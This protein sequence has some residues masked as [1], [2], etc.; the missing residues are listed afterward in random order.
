MSHL[1]KG[2]STLL[3]TLLLL[4]S[5]TA[6]VSAE[7][8]S[9]TLTATF[10]VTFQTQATVD[11]EAALQAALI[12]EH[13]TDIYL[14]GDIVLSQQLIN[15]TVNKTYTIYGQK[16]TVSAVPGANFAN[17][18]AIALGIGNITIQNA[19]FANIT[20]Q[21]IIYAYKNP[22]AALAPPN[23]SVQ[24]S[25]CTFTNGA[26]AVLSYAYTQATNV[27][28]TLQGN[29]FTGFNG[30]NGQVDSA[31]IYIEG[32]KAILGG[33]NEAEKNTLSN[34]NY[35][36]AV[37]QGVKIYTDTVIDTLATAATAGKAIYTR[38]NI[39]N[40]IAP[41]QGADV[42]I[43]KTEASQSW[44][45]RH[46]DDIWLED[47]A[48][49]PVTISWDLPDDDKVT[50]GS[51]INAVINQSTAFTISVSVNDYAVDVE[52]ATLVL[53]WTDTEANPIADG[54]TVT[55]TT[56]LGAMTAGSTTNQNFTVTFNTPG[57]YNISLYAE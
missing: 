21:H 51:Q 10:T 43:L 50:P 5:V 47:E 37:K 26:G 1:Q 49:I 40:S 45:A 48:L 35:G 11:N 57:T 33:T 39:T 6:F 16:H 28:S 22:G 38:N 54:I 7:P 27:V 55:G 25:G 52:N 41:P 13:I 2:V 44:Y 20:A 30:N 53:Q 3:I 15:E 32:G 9:N 4:F 34:N 18:Q 19:V 56:A 17:N 8:I 23:T 29:T 12:D 31:G 46:N 42:I 14:S 36:I 24:I